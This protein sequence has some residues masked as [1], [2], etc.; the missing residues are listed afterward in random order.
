MAGLPYVLA[1]AFMWGL[2]GI[3]TKYILAEGVSALEIA[4]WRAT[5]AWIFFM[6]HAAVTG[7]ARAHRS[8]LPTLLGFGFVCAT[9]AGAV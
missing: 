3:F 9:Q 1:A 6:A 5:I 7:Q 2:I 8:D 4:F